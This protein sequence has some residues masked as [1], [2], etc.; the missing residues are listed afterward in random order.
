MDKQL[1]RELDQ[2][3]D[4]LTIEIHRQ[5]VKSQSANAKV[6]E[7]CAWPSGPKS[8]AAIGTAGVLTT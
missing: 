7:L 1:L 5:V 4:K 2:H 8:Q 6:A 3:Q